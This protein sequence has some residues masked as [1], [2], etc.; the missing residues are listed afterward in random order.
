MF[1]NRAQRS[2]LSEWQ[3]DPREE[4]KKV[5]LFLLTHNRKCTYQ[6]NIKIVKIDNNIILFEWRYQN[7]SKNSQHSLNVFCYLKEWNNIYI[8]C[9][10]ERKV[11]EYDKKVKGESGFS[12]LS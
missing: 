11:Y 1:D 7:Y 5:I 9:R 8:Y 6:K 3:I 2:G 10:R 4:K 12:T